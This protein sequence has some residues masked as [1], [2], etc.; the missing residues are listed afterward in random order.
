MLIG[1]RLK[2]LRKKAKMTQTRLAALSGVSVRTITGIESL[3][4]SYEFTLKTLKQ[5]MAPFKVTV[6]F[7]TKRIHLG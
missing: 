6:Q 7:K 3:D 2:L 1:K 4:A 5:V